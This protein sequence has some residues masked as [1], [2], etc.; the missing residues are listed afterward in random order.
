MSSQI[1][2]SEKR[3]RVTLV[4]NGSSN[5]R[6]ALPRLLRISVADPDATDSSGDEEDDRHHLPL[7]RLHVRRYVHEIGIEACPRSTR[8]PGGGVA[9][10]SSLRGRRFRG[11]RQRP[12]G[13]WAAEIRDPARKRRVWLG[14]YNTAEEAARVYDHAAVLLRGPNAMTNFAAPPSRPADEPAAESTATEGYDSGEDSHG[15]SS[16]TSVLRCCSKEEAPEDSDLKWQHPHQPTGWA[17][18]PETK[19]VR[20]EGEGRG[21]GDAVG[22]VFEKLD[23]GLTEV[24][25]AT[26]PFEVAPPPFDQ[27]LW[28]DDTAAG[29]GFG[30]FFLGARNA[31]PRRRGDY[32]E[33]FGNIGD[34]FSSDPLEVF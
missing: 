3:D 8:A 18:T 14:T 23:L 25:G 32:F 27:L 31:T 21:G 16:P 12:W 22:D 6:L 9:A 17:D 20:S 11:V 33:D 29:G 7:R 28:F 26:L 34:F 24:F 19:R 13:K 15:L 2:F 5:G 4:S 10:R 1:K 30:D